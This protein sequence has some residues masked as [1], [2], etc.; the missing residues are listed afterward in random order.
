[1]RQPEKNRCKHAGKRMKHVLPAKFSSR[2]AFAP[3]LSRA[4]DEPESGT[5]FPVPV[6]VGHRSGRGSPPDA[7][8]SPP[9]LYATA[10]G[11]YRRYTTTLRNSGTSLPISLAITKHLTQPDA[12]SSAA[13]AF[14]TLPP[15]KNDRFGGLHRAVESAAAFEAVLS[16]VPDSPRSE[17][18]KP[19][20][21]L[22]YGY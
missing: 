14:D 12:R 6:S 2:P 19:R 7:S 17:A 4:V 1:M 9:V 5:S 13:N 10:K 20:M 16:D 22:T 3:S 18:P 15:E 21:R 11:T 8:R